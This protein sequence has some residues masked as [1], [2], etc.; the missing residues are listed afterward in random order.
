MEEEGGTAAERKSPGER[1]AS[2]GRAGEWASGLFG[3]GP[4]EGKQGPQN[5]SSC[6]QRGQCSAVSARADVSFL[7]VSP[8][9][10]CLPFLPDTGSKVVAEFHV[11]GFCWGHFL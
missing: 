8:Y 7:T 10:C 1:W 11:T 6:T 3:L 9:L 5:S 2:D 4:G